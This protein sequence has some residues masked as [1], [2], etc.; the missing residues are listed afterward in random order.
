MFANFDVNVQNLFD[1]PCVF[2]L[3]TGI[4]MMVYFE[5]TPHPVTVTTRMISFLVENPCKPSFVTVAGCGVDRRY[6]II[7]LKLGSQSFEV[8]NAAGTPSQARSFAC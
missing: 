1:I 6:L 8:L 5:T 7:P 4:L 3:S 2:D